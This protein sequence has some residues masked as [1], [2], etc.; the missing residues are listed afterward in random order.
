MKKVISGRLYNTEKARKVGEWSST[1]Y[2]YDVRDFHWYCETLYCKRNGEYF[3]HGEGGPMS[4][5]AKSV[6]QNQWSSGEAITPVSLDKAKEWAESHL[7]ADEYDSEFG[8]P[9]EGSEHD[10]HTII[11][12]DTWQALD[13]AA[14]ADGITVGAIIDRL[15]KELQ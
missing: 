9:E 7:D 10:L 15:A 5:Y 8:I 3:I 1:E 4:H 2:T 14:K 12:E 11:L 6:G 13:R